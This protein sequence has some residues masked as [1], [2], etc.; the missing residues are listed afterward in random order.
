[1][2][3]TALFFLKWDDMQNRSLPNTFFCPTAYEN[4]HRAI[5]V[6]L[7]AF[8][9]N[10]FLR[11]ST[12]RWPKCR[13]CCQTGFLKKCTHSTFKRAITTLPIDWLLIRQII[14]DLHYYV[15][16]ISGFCWNTSNLCNVFYYI[17][18]TFIDPWVWTPS[19]TM[20]EG[21][22]WLE[23]SWIVLTYCIFTTRR[24]LNHESLDFMPVRTCCPTLWNDSLLEQ[25]YLFLRL[26]GVPLQ[27]LAAQESLGPVAPLG[28]PGSVLLISSCL[29]YCPQPAWP[30]S[31]QRWKSWWSLVEEKERQNG[32]K[33]NGR[34]WQDYLIDI[35]VH[36]HICILYIYAIHWSKVLLPVSCYLALPYF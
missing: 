11:K 3:I 9:Y 24:G 8:Y 15:T 20:K 14:T 23:L 32:R 26:E 30:A 13:M 7:A 28:G 1:M 36:I 25:A 4:I 18:D 5:R 29:S 31:G 2:N 10:I 6:L 22:V 17:W 34:S 21:R 27:T 16:V 12:W 35:Y 33:G 19:L